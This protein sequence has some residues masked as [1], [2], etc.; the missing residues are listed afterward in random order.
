MDEQKVGFVTI[1]DVLQPLM[2]R[3]EPSDTEMISSH[4]VQADAIK[5]TL[6]EHNIDWQIFCITLSPPLDAINSTKLSS[7]EE[8]I[9]NVAQNLIGQNVKVTKVS[10]KD[11][12]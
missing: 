11:S 9:Q 5:K 1:N 10:G 4:K 3:E 7:V 12:D 2:Q 6:I 8:V